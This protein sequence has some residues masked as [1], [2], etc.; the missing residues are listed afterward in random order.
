MRTLLAPL[1]ALLALAPLAGAQT[2]LYQTAFDDGSGWTYA[3]GTCAWDV[4]A[5]PAAM[6]GGAF[7][8][9]PSSLNCNRDS[10]GYVSC[11][12]RTA[13]SPSLDL[14]PAAG[15]S[16]TLSFWC[17]YDVEE[18]DC[19]VD[20]RHLMISDDGFQ[21][22]LVDL[23]Y[24]FADCAASGTWHEH[25]LP[26]DPAWGVVQL[27]FFFDVHDGLFCNEC[28]DGWFVDDLVVTADCAPPV[29]YCTPKVNSQGCTPALSTTGV[30]SA[31]GAGTLRVL[32]DQVLS[33]QPG[34]L[35]WSLTAAS[36]PFAGGTLCVA[37]PVIRTP[38]Q[39][40]GGSPPPLD[41]TG[42][43]SYQFTPA[44]LAAN[45]LVPG[46]QVHAQYWSR[47]PGF[48]GSNA[49]GLTS[50]VAFTVCP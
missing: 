11:F 48:S 33:Q 47:D 14:A 43:Y 16:A 6:V 25:Q 15:A 19:V 8:S 36:T 39:F 46:T 3:A 13:D 30:P 4:D 7:R 20:T 49:F 17:N 28:H 31:S 34:V 44:Y 42:A 18:D 29:P 41:C 23:C 32:A 12:D 35:I 10:G 2:V 27:R 24:Q 21:S 9:A 38:A 50:A 40:A 45:N 1:A 26:L 37:P 22:L 5:E